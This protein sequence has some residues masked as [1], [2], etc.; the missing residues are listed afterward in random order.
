MSDYSFLKSGGSVLAEPMKM[1][2]K[3]MED[4][5][6]ILGLFVS[7]SIK[8]AAQ[9]VEYCGRNGIT[10]EDIRY[11]LRLEVFEF[12]KR[13]DLLEGIEEI[14]QEMLNEDE[15]DEDGYDK[16]ENEN[17]II[18]PEDEL[19]NFERISQD[20]L[21]TLN[22]QNREFIDKLHSYSNDW[23]QWTP[24]TPLEKILKNAIDKIG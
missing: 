24:V 7:N 3:E 15:D 21:N 5:E 8:T 23:D 12:L 16:N 13:P 22:T 10:K 19:N 18:I 11:S 6:S 20:K 2:D 14:K 4:I 17:P 9:Y 1:S